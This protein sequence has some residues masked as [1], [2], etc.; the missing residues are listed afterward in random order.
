M[1]INRF[2]ITINDKTSIQPYAVLLGAF[3]IFVLS[4]LYIPRHPVPINLYTVG[5]LFVGLMYNRSNA[6]GSILTYLGAGAIGAPVF[7]GLKGGFLHMM[8]PTGGY[9]FGAIPAVWAMTTL[10]PFAV[11]ANSWMSYFTLSII[12]TSIIFACGIAWLSH[13][14]GLNNAIHNGLLPFIFSGFL[15]SV[16]LAA[17]LRF[18]KK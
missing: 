6:M 9:L 18:V 4:Q 14:I 13:F 12:G 15:K 8:G 5:V 17:L 2:N 3:I 11:N 16:L 10:R 1:F 7:F